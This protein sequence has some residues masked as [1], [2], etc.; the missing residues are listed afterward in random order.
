MA[1][2]RVF[3]CTLNV[4]V[5]SIVVLLGLMAISFSSGAIGRAIFGG[6]ASGIFAVPPPHHELPANQISPGLPV[7]NTMIV[8]WIS[9][10]VLFVSFFTATRKMKLVP[11]GLQNFVEFLY[12]SAAN[13][14]EDAAGKENGRRFFPIV[15][16]IFLFVV[17]NAWLALI[18]G[19]GTITINGAPLLRGANT[20]INLPLAL[21]VVAFFAIEYW[22]FTSKGLKRY[23][24]EFCNLTPFRQCLAQLLRGKIKPALSNLFNGVIS[25]FTGFL[26]ILSH[27]IRMVSF[28][29]R[30]FGNMTAGEILILAITFIIP[31]VLPLPFYGLELFFGFVQALIFGGLT[32]SFACAAVM[33][34]E[35]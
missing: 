29:F 27:L 28:T 1:R 20:D 26:E 24:K 14:V 22:G 21:A 31:W 10:L 33:T 13:F 6:E 11:K 5:I 3:G 8:S 18:P 7:T 17:T 2:R 25:L 19:F 12:E 32:L 16:T 30:L 23:I 9:I 35:E 15:V 4:L 34:K